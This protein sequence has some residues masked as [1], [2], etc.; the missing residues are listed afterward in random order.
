MGDRGVSHLPTESQSRLSIGLSG[1]QQTSTGMLRDGPFLSAK[2]FASYARMKNGCMTPIIHLLSTATPIKL[3][4]T[5][6]SGVEGLV[7]QKAWY[8]SDVVGLSKS[9]GCFLS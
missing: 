8:S 4:S 2:L 5:N 9:A 1:D 7:Y 6:A 3:V